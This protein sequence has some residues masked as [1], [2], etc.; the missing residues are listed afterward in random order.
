MAPAPPRASRP[1][2]ASAGLGHDASSSGIQGNSTTVSTVLAGAATRDET[3][4][5]CR[6]RPN[7]ESIYTEKNWYYLLKISI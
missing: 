5:G 6:L 4:S 1:R 3:G 2:Q 7:R